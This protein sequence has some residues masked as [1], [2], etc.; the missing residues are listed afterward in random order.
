MDHE[1]NENISGVQYHFFKRHNKFF[2]IPF[3]THNYIKSQ[4]PDVIIAQGLVFPVQVIALRM[5]VGKHCKIIV[6]HHGEKPFKGVKKI[7]QKI[8]AKYVDAYLFTAIEISADW[9]RT[10]IINPAK[11]FEILPASTWF[12]QQD[13]NSC[14]EKLDFKGQ[15]NFLWVGRLNENKDPMTVIKAFEKYLCFQQDAKLHMVFQANDLLNE[16]QESI[17]QTDTLNYSVKLHGKIPHN[18]LP[19]WYSAADFYISAS[20]NESC[21]YALLEA[22][23]CGCIPIVT[24]IPSFKKI[25]GDGKYGFLFTPGETDELLKILCDLK[26]I[27]REEFSKNV[28]QYF[29]SKLSYKNIAEDLYNICVSILS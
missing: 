3:T 15:H 5:R 21:G 9:V 8:A 24:N 4:K 12:S 14:K 20:H 27:N 17:W 25:T 11:C 16:I 1:G 7:F 28:R 29:S 10:N 19:Y 26:S 2:Q 22:M 18:E 13:K 6:Q 23:S